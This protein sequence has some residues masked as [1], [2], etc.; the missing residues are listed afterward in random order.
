ML[1][2]PV[3]TI[4]IWAAPHTVREGKRLYQAGCVVDYSVDGTR[5]TGTVQLGAR[6]MLT[7][8][9]VLADGSIDSSICP[10]RDCRE[11]GITCANAV[12]VGLAYLDS[13]SDPRRDRRI[14]IEQRL[15]ER[16]AEQGRRYVQ[17]VSPEQ[18]DAVPAQLRI[19]LR[20]DWRQELQAR[21]SVHLLVEAEYRGN[22]T[23]L[24]KVGRHLALTWS[25]GDEYLLHIL[26]DF[27]D[28]EPVSGELELDEIQFADLLYELSDQT[29]AVQGGSDLLVSRDLLR[30]H[31]A[32]KL[33][34]K[35]GELELEHM[36][37]DPEEEP[38]LFVLGDHIGWMLAE[39]VFHPMDQKVPESLL[40]L[41]QE[42]LR[43]PRT[44][45]LHFMERELPA[46]EKCMTVQ[47]SVTTSDFKRIPGDPSFRLVVAGTPERAILKLH[48]D[49]EGLP[50]PLA[51]QDNEEVLFAV[52]VQKDIRSYVVRN[53]EKENKALD[54]LSDHGCHLTAQRLLEPVESTR[55]VMRF[56]GRD[57]P[58]VQHKGWTVEFE[59][60][61]A[62]LAERS[63][64]VHPVVQIE[65]SAEEGWF[66]VSYHYVD[67]AGL[68]VDDS[69]VEHAMV[70]GCSFF[71]E[72]GRLFVLDLA[73]IESVHDVFDDCSVKESRPCGGVR[74]GDIH[75]GYAMSSLQLIDDVRIQ[76][77][78]AWNR[79]VAEQ[80][81]QV[82]LERVRIV[83][84]L[85]GILRPYQKE[86]VTWLRYLETCGFCGILADEMGLGKTVQTLAWLQMERGS[87]SAQGAPALI[88]CP[89]SLVENW[90]D[91]AKKFT[92]DLKIHLFSGATRR[93]TIDRFDEVDVVITSYA[94]LRRDIHLYEDRR[95]SVAVLDE[96]Q[97][98]KN[99]STQN[100]KAAKRVRAAHRL[101]LTGTPI[102]NSITDLWSI[103]DFLMPKYLGNHRQ[104]RESYELPLQSPGPAADI[105]QQ[106][107]KRKVHPFM[108][109][110]LKKDVVKE[111]PP[112]IE[113]IASCSMSTDQRRVY[114]QL[115]SNSRNHVYGLVAEKGFK[116]SRFEIFKTLT[117]L[118]QACC[119]LE[120]LKMPGIK[121][122]APSGKLE[123]F[124]ELLDE[125][126]DGGN[127]ILVFSQF[128]SMLKILQRELEARDI[129]YCY[130]DGSTRERMKE[131]NR[132][133]NTDSIPV[134]LISLK[135][136]GTGLNLTGADTVIHYDP[137]WNP[138]VEDQ[139]T[140]RAHRIG[141]ERTVYS[142]KLITRDS[143]EEKVLALQ[144][145][146]KLLI[147]ATLSADDTVL[148]KLSWDD[149]QEL[150]AT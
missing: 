102:E 29:L 37:G 5:I 47:T 128:V 129:P 40:G 110:R 12:A 149:V 17:Q 7:R 64:W 143:V 30:P 49:Y 2:L 23:R 137:W 106:R 84:E 138:A 33:D 145:R 69:V 126:I 86:G 77:D 20:K 32:V 44:R 80:N 75:A 39:S 91:E 74:V 99:H 78:E 132:F 10:C 117:R 81:R 18:E 122:D 144:R 13:I 141:Q 71:E 124:H 119:H 79:R 94:L 41:Y 76:A 31:I 65:A 142:M 43:I 53:M 95:F 127:R 115:L 21:R 54:W 51:G 70:D 56:I 133:N 72:D 8:F 73:A 27:L 38:D 9:T 42:T 61:F 36:A 66:D 45:L 146:K 114:D 4:E 89:T 103:V 148:E 60:G 34:Q 136:G 58:L 107:L 57:I 63:E 83:P 19:R 22:C 116:Q 112:K 28:G 111:L 3:S 131:V 130:L 24:H 16:S 118:R 113:K 123:L 134:F 150:L 67:D 101:V 25:E 120:L 15:A 6:R 139:A 121:C 140:D 97:H 59:E 105:V 87:K 55:G 90:A 100:A 93:K 98:I 62:E 68:P 147:S 82:P 88:V 35:S 11:R 50:G 125:A 26:E 104:F 108:L 92:P 52:P 46:I 85:E 14:R 135:A 48:A 96:A 109:R 1:Y